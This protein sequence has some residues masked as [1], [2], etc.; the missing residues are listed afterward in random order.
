MDAPRPRVLIAD[1]SAPVV[2]AL[3]RLV[4]SDCDIVGRL[5]DGS[6]LLA[7]TT[8][9]QPDI[10][11][12]DLHLP[13]VNSLSACEDIRRLSS[14]TRVI[15]VTGGL[16][17]DLRRWVLAAGATAFIDKAAPQELLA[18]IADIRIV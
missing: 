2:A 11:L 14:H 15:V 6:S 5:T 1:D 3:E 16:N 7:E 18:A 8:R 9:L 13:G 17:P 12:L 4:A 10:L